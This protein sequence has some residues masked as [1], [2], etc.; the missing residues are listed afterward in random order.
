MIAALFIV[1]WLQGAV[2]G[3]SIPHRARGVKR[4][5]LLEC[6]PDDLP[7][8]VEQNQG[9]FGSLLDYPRAGRNNGGIGNLP[10]QGILL[11]P[12]KKTVDPPIVKQR[13][14]E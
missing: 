6:A 1:Q 7:G 4:Q 5:G 11:S 14:F 2:G 8:L 12:I 13:L 3:L 10:R 9:R